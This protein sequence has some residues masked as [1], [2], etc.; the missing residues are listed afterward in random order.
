MIRKLVLAAL[1]GMALRF[2]QKRLRGDADPKPLRSDSTRWQSSPSPAR[3]AIFTGGGA[4]G[5]PK[6]SSRV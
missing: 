6:P 5:T 1:G 4:D 3:D 2:V